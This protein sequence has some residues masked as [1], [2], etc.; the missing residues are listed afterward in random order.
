MRKHHN[1]SIRRRALGV[2][3]FGA[4]LPLLA[5]NGAGQGGGGGEHQIG[6]DIEKVPA[7][8]VDPKVDRFKVQ[9][10][11]API[12]GTADAKVTIIEISDFQ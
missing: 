9:I 2:L 3:A 10:G 11:S 6:R 12:E 5:C 8:A 7:G 4:V 1:G